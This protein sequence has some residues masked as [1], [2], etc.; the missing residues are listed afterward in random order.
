MPRSGGR[1]GNPGRAA[2]AG[3]AERGSPALLL[4]RRAPDLHA[5]A[6]PADGRWL[7]PVT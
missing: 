3:K 6:P 5:H 7:I 4:E 1:Q 2:G